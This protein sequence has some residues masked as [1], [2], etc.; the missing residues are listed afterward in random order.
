MKDP[1]VDQCS[2]TAHP[3]DSEQVSP[4]ASLCLSSHRENKGINTYLPEWYERGHMQSLQHSARLEA[5][6]MAAMI[7]AITRVTVP[8]DPPSQNTT[9]LKKEKIIGRYLSL[10][11][12]KLYV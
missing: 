9:T 10:K 7:T 11:F 8:L 2:A 6:H 1:D 12:P 5:K 4:L 3:C